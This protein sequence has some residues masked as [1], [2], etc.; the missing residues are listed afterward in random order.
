MSEA[1]LETVGKLVEPTRVH[2]S[3]YVDPAIFDLEMERIFGHAWVLIGHDSQ[4]PNPGDYFTTIVGRQPVIMVRHTDGS[5]R[6]LYN[7]CG[8]RGA[9][10]VGDRAGNARFFRCCYH[11][12]TFRTDG[13]VLSVPLRHGYDDT[14]FDAQNPAFW[15]PRA[16]RSDSYRGFVFA[17]LAPEGPDLTSFLG[18]VASSLDDFVDRA[19]GGRV[20]VAGRPFRVM[21]RNNWK[22]FFENLNDAMHALVVHESSV[23]AARTEIARMDA[24]GQ[25]SYAADVIP[26]MDKNG[27]PYSSWEKLETTAFEWG[28]SY[29][30]GFFNPESYESSYV[31]ALEKAHGNARMREILSVN[32]HNTI[33]YPSCSTQSAYQQ[34]R[35]I[36]PIAV[37]RTMV[38]IYNFR[39]QGAP[40][41]TYRRTMIFT[42]LTNSPSSIVMPDDVEAYNR[43]QEGLGV[44]GADW[45]S[46]D[47]EAGRETRN[48][49]ALT[50]PATSEMPM[51][52]QMRVWRKYMTAET[53]G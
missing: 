41:D 18:G 29:L 42:N 31:E 2:R 20:E 6:V 33:I 19:P 39:L 27:L 7:R 12:W 30:G 43:V 23:D 25:T 45:I 22:V 51:R 28:H 4:I 50:A 47:R 11:G 37:D 17:S 16:A 8:H 48:N 49:G 26:T 34:L 36:R 32:R 5:I 14:A 3:I 40:A 21:Q 13:Q 15:M 35:V 53:L 46:F 24:E 10:V 9:K 44:N 52:N 38:E 1:S